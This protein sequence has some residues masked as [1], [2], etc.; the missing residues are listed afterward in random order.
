[1][2]LEELYLC[3]A[4]VEDE[5][6]KIQIARKSGKPVPNQKER[7]ELLWDEMHY[8]RSVI[9]SLTSNNQDELIRSA[10]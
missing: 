4:E 3:R 6:D 8:I 1:M 7:L 9:L 2:N 10:E 5:I